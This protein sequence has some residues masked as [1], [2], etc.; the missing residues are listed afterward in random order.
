MLFVVPV[1]HD[2]NVVFP[3]PFSGD[4][5][6]LGEGLLG[7]VFPEAGDKLALVVPLCVVSFFKEFT[8]QQSCLREAIHATDY[9]DGVGS[10]LLYFFHY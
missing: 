1:K 9:H 6:V 4:L 7:I 8:G 10:V 5:V 2:T 3:I